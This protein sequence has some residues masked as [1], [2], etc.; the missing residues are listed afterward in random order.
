MISVYMKLNH[1]IK[2]NPKVIEFEKKFKIKIYRF[3]IL[4]N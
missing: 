4:K 1:V 2:L 3:K